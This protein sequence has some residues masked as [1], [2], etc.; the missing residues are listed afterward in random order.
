MMNFDGLDPGLGEYTA[1]LHGGLEP[2]LD[3]SL[4]PAL[5]QAVEL[6]P[7]AMAVAVAEGMYSELHSVASEVGVPVTTTH[8]DLHEELLWIGNHRGHAS[9]FF[10]PTMGRYS[11]F[12]VHLADDIRHIQSMDTGVL[13]L[14]KSNL[15]C[16]TRGGLVMFDYPMEEGADMHSLLLT[17]NNTLL[18]GGLQNY[19][20]EVDLNTVQE[21]QKFTVEIPGVAIMRQSNRFFF[22][23]HTSGKVSLRDLRTFK[24][25]HE[26]DAYSGSLSDFDVHG[27]LLAACGFS[28]RGLNGMSCDRFLM[29]YDLRMMRAVTPLQVHVDPL[30]LRF[31]PTYTSRLAIISQTGQCQFCEPT[32]LAN[33]ADIFHVSTVGQLLMSFDVSSSKQALAFGDSG[34]CVHLWSSAQEVSFN[35]YSRETELA[36][37]CLVDSLPQLDWNHELVPLSLVPMP[38]T[39]TEPLFSDWPSTLITPSPRRAPAVDPEILRTMK[40]VGFIGYA[41]NPRTRPRNQVPYKIKEVELEYDNYNQVPESPIGRDEEPHLYM[42]PKKY[43]KVTIKYSKLGLEDFDFKHYNRTL[44]AGLEPHIPNAY[45][46]C[47]IQVLYFLEPVRCLVQNHLCQKEFCLACELGFLFH[48]LDLSR[49]DPC[50]ASNFLRAFRTIPEAS[51]L[52]LILADSDEQT[53]KARLG[54]LIQSWNC[55]ILTQLHQETQEQEGPQAYRGTSSTLGSSGESV[56]GRL[57]GCEVENSS[58]CRCGKE[59]VRSS[60]TLLFTM[61]YPEQSSL[62]KFPE[63]DFAEILKKSICLEQSTQ[64]WCENCEKYQPTVQTRNIRCLPDVLVINCEVNSMKEAEFWKAQAEY[65]FNKALKK[66]ATELPKPKEPLPTEWCLEDEVYS[67]ETFDTRPEDLR[68]VWIPQ[69]LKMCINKTH[70]LEVC[71]WLETEELGPEEESEGAAVYDLVVTVPHILD[72]RTGG[73]LVAHIKVGETYHQR[74]EGV[75]HQQ[76]YLFNDFLIEPIDKTEA[77]QFDLNWKVPAIIYYAKRNYHNKYDL[78]IKNPIEA[79]VLL[80]EASL[81]RK[82]RKSHATFIPLMVSEMPQAGDLVGLDAEFVTLNQEEAELR[83]D[84]TKSTIKPSQMSVARI[85]CVRGQGP[86]EGVPFIDDYI[87]TQEQVVDYLTQYSGIKP[88]DLDAKISSKHLTTLKSTYLKLRFLIDTGV[89]FV[90]HGLQK[91]FRVINLMVLKDQVI[92]TVYL[93]HMP[94]KRMISLRFL[95]WYFLDLNIQSETHDSIEDART[96]LQLYRKYLELSRRGQE[97]FRK[98]LK[99]LYEKGR[100]LD[101]KVPESD[102]A[103]SQGSPK[104]TAVFPSVLGL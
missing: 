35:D 92:D 64:A 2:G 60:L 101:W 74:K 11:S 102:S 57:F 90:G 3:S 54:R 25:E 6:D 65:S 61:H 45:C 36:L 81:A 32:G 72:P 76:W 41:Q 55:F 28:S 5:L 33:L 34:G 29:V 30:F 17:E 78:R 15:K 104:G 83:S 48:M 68:H 86:N 85:T 1:G 9:S 19:V 98:V 70:G 12:Q 49:G 7:D 50:Q 51:A 84:G 4:D 79:N 100:K 63:Y 14:T 69:S 13:F 91:D 38:L 56:I 42:V 22:C 39:S 27:N 26:F 23:G 8:F 88:G 37:P 44:F 71:S 73:N 18:L 58:L 52:G 94:R 95:A 31:I 103:E 67:V 82:Q 77:A 46:N 21:T 53:G 47:M 62:E 24:M 40:T 10:G 93:F 96:A 43:R 89:R 59:T 99:G 20:T 87:S 80:T 75:T 66:G 97:E 16:L